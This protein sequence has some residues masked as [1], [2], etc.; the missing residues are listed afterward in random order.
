MSVTFDLK[1]QT[2]AIDLAVSAG[3]KRQSERTGFIHLFPQEKEAW[4]T[5][6]FYENLCFV[7][8]LFRQKAADAVLEGKELLDKLL[9]FQLE[10]GNFPVFLHEFPRGKDAY[11]ALRV[12][13]ILLQLERKFSSILGADLKAKI[14]RSLQK[15]LSF[16]AKV[17]QER[18]YPLLWENRFRACFKQPLLP[19]DVSLLSPQEWGE[20]VITVQLAD[21]LDLLETLPFHS[22]LQV[23]L[24]PISTDIQERFEPQPV[25]L[26]WALA[27]RKAMFTPR[28]LQ[29][30]PHQILAAPL[31]PLETKTQETT[32]ILRQ[33]GQGPLSVLWQGKA[34]HSLRSSPATW[35]DPNEQGATLNFQLSQPV[36]WKREDLFEISFHCDASSETQVFVEGQKATVFQLNDRVT[37]QTPSFSLSLRFTLIEGEGDFCGHIA[38][39]NR[40]NQCA[41]KG[42]LQYE[43][44]DWHIGLRTLRRSDACQIQVDL[45]IQNGSLFAD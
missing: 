32:W 26:E 3:R 27:E 28:L 23:L 4:D 38:R 16:A 13:P 42:L 33:E 34:L 21:R 39:G 45:S 29:D 44:F 25:A 15:L 24:G 1:K 20:W 17:R 14:E 11:L 18:P 10:E 5:I 12:A 19:V 37:V 36:V 31:F 35:I 43:A 9:G 40:A 2:R 8:A 22:N 30:H 6:P 41:C 7:L